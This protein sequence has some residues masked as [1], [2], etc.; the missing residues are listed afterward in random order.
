MRFHVETFIY[1]GARID[2]VISYTVLG[3]VHCSDYRAWLSRA[4][5]GELP[6]DV[7]KSFKDSINE[8]Q[9]IRQI[10]L[11]RFKESGFWPWPENVKV[12]QEVSH[13]SCEESA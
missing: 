3:N 5:Y 10:A 6:F 2:A 1:S 13:G 9:Q 11:T 7:T 4:E 12:K 8:D